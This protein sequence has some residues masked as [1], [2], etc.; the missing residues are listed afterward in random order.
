MFLAVQVCLVIAGVVILF[1]GRFNFGD[2]VVGQ[3]MASLIGLVL[4]IQ[5]P[6]A[7]VLWMML[8]IGEPPAAATKVIPTRA[9][10][11]APTVTVSTLKG[12]ADEYW[13]VDPFVTCGAVMIAAV[14]IGIALRNENASDEVF[15]TLGLTKPEADPAQ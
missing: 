4:V 7:L 14:L 10:E 13:W 2:R 1:R 11:A 8:W 3:P 6:V 5:L 9:G 15:E 12:L